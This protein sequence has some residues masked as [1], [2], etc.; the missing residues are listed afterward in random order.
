VENLPV[1]S[2]IACGGEHSLA[3]TAS[4]KVLGWGS[5]SKLQLS[6]LDD[7]ANSHSP[8]LTTF[9]PIQLLFYNQVEAISAGDEF[10]IFLTRNSCNIN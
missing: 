2:L 8:M 5:N 7:F 6:H 4:G 9:Q 3:L 10:S 1:V